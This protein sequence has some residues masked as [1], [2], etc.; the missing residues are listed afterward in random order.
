MLSL[1]NFNQWTYKQEINPCN[2]HVR[3]PTYADFCHTLQAT[4]KVNNHHLSEKGLCSFFCWHLLCLAFLFRTRFA[5]RHKV[6][7]SL[8]AQA[9]HKEVLLQCKVCSPSQ[10]CYSSNTCSWSFHWYPRSDITQVSLEMT[11]PTVPPSLFF[12]LRGRHFT[13]LHH[14]K[15]SLCFFSCSFSHPL[16]SAFKKLFSHWVF[17]WVNPVTF[18]SPQAMEMCTLAFIYPARWRAHTQ[19]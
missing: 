15:N 12:F 4:T 3:S 19:A 9:A 1:L 7:C 6:L 10:R 8:E 11:S 13:A 18:S 2:F 17:P 16:S 14:S 5:T